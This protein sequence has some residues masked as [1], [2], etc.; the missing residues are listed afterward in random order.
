MLLKLKFA[1]IKESRRES[2]NGIKINPTYLD[3][4]VEIRLQTTPRTFELHRSSLF[5]VAIFTVVEAKEKGK[6]E[7]G[8]APSHFVTA[9]GL[10]GGFR[11][12]CWWLLLL[13]TGCWVRQLERRENRERERDNEKERG[14]ARRN[15][16]PVVLTGTGER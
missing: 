6:A 15:H 7:R 3:G 11:R 9:R 1:I 8:A 13:L 5:L 16:R 10:L 14:R 12:S 2:C 4:S